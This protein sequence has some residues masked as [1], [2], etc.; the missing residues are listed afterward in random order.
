MKKLKDKGFMNRYS[1][2][3]E[4]AIRLRTVMRRRHMS[5]VTLS[6]RTGITQPSISRY[7]NGKSVP[8]SYNLYK[9]CK[10][11]NVSPCELIEF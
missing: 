5:E 1:F 3:Q 10:V 8:Q 6:D 7:L 2:K 11:L 4:F 9:I